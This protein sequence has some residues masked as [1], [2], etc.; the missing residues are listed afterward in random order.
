MNDPRASFG[1]TISPQRQEIYVAGGYI[2]GVPTDKCEVYS[3]QNDKW[4]RLPDLSEKKCSTSL[5]ILDNKFLYAMGGLSKAND[6]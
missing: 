6:T 1:C 3:I 5:C 4:R 2:N